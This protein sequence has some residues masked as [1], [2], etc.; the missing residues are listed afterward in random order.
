MCVSLHNICIAQNQRLY[1]HKSVSPVSIMKDVIFSVEEFNCRNS[2]A[3]AKLSRPNPTSD[4]LL[5]AEL[6]VV[7]VDAGVFHD[8]SV[9]FGCVFRNQQG[10][11]ILAASK[12]E[13]ISVAPDMAEF[14]AIR[15][16]LSIAATLK[17][18]KVLIQSDAKSVVDCINDG[19]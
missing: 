17:L 5:P 9:S 2:D 1:Q 15:W 7:Q 14:L 13:F 4:L 11:I 6:N 12:T 10:D 3:G 18:D 16:C 19:V 8:G